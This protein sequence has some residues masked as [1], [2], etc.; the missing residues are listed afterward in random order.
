MRELSRSRNVIW[1]ENEVKRMR[2]VRE[3]NWKDN[4]NISVAEVL[5]F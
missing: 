2:Y 1:I 4:N 3:L 5:G